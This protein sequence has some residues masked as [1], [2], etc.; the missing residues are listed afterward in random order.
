[1]GWLAKVKRVREVRACCRETPQ[2]FPLTLAYLALRPLSYPYDLRLRTGEQITLNERTDLIVFWLV[3]CKRQYPVNASDRTIID[4]G[5]NIGMY[6]L[7]AARQA[8]QATIIAIESFPDTCSRLQTMVEKNGLRD[9][10]KI[11]NCAVRGTFSQ[12][13][14]DSA[15]QVPSQYRRIYSELTQSMNRK[16]RKMVKQGP[17]GITVTAEPL[18]GLLDRVDIAAADLMKMNIHGSEYEVLMSAP[19]GVLRRCKEIAVTYH[20]MPPRTRLGKRPLIAHML[21]N[22]YRL[23]SDQDTRQGSGLAVFRLPD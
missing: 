10:V 17:D 15:P 9:R 7:Y 6:T 1:M 20:E 4:V 18:A 8:P 12:V 11:L 22:G 23:V 19:T 16:H 14:M 13:T 21:S 2:W 3:F 5:A